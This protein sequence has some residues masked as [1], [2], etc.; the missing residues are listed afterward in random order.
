MG[1][2]LVKK[3]LRDCGLPFA[4]FHVLMG[5][6]GVTERILSLGVRQKRV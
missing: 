2:F 3:I 5:Q 6:I 1:L 4:E